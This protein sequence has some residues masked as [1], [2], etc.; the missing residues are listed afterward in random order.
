MVVRVYFVIDFLNKWC[1]IGVNYMKSFTKITTKIYNPIW[2]RCNFSVFTDEFKQIR[3]M[4]KYKCD[5]CIKCY[6]KFNIGESIAL[7]CFEN[8]GNKVMCNECAKSIS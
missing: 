7:A 5:T 4:F 6:H 3:S 8:I 1:M 2:I